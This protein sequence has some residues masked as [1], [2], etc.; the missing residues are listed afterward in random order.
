MGIFTK[1]FL[2]QPGGLD[3]QQNHDSKKCKPCSSLGQFRALAP[4]AQHCLPP[5][6]MWNS[7]HD[8]TMRRIKMRQ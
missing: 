6:F 3:D 4:A 5:A 1:P 7:C 8:F 2:P